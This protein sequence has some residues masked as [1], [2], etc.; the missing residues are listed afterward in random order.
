MKKAIFSLVAILVAF[1]SNAQLLWKVSGNGLEKPSYLMGT[2]HVAP[3]SMLDSI[4]GFEDAINNCDAIYGEV[5]QSEMQGQEAQQKMMAMAMAPA[6]STLNVLFTP[7]EYAKVDSV[8]RK[9]TNGMATLQQ[10]NPL[11]PAIV[12]TQLAMLQS[13]QVFPGFDPTKQIDM[14]VQ[15]R[16]AELGK[17]FNGLETVDFQLE[18]LFGSPLTEQAETL[19]ES[20]EKDALYYEFAHKLAQAYRNQDLDALWTLMTD[21]ELGFDE[22]ELDKMI[23]SRNV[24]WVGQLKTLMPGQALM[25]CVGAGHL[26][27]DKGVIALLRA[28]GFTIEPVK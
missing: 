23:F 16:G 5:K 6:D 22:K 26:P 7:E 25:I 18:M 20:A 21:E 11:K 4:A 15:T 19:L 24:N 17:P 2:H 13:M 3:I 1:A 14:Y 27:G 9:Y 8:I 10:M 12:S 28:E